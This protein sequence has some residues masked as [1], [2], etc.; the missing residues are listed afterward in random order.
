M[1]I[2]IF[3]SSDNNYAPYMAATIVSI[4]E[5]TEAFIN[6]YILDGGIS[7]QNIEKISSMGKNYDNCSLEFIKLDVEKEFS[8]IK[9][10]NEHC[11]H[12][13][14]SAL[15]RLLI[16]NLKHDLKKVIYLDTDIIAKKDIKS[17]YEY[18]LGEYALGAVPGI[19]K[20][21]ADNG[22]RRLHLSKLHHYFNSGV[23]LMDL[24]KFRKQN[25]VKRFFEIEQKKRELIKYPDQDIL[26]ICFENNYLKLDSIYNY[27]AP[28][29]YIIE[30]FVLRHYITDIKPWHINPDITGF[31]DDKDLFWYYMRKTP[32]YEEVF[33]IFKYKPKNF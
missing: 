17:L 33:Q 16:P 18:D 13:T 28:R 14:L 4:L 23:L 3:L 7:D 20:I 10:N 1:S 32:F 27:T 19:V 21:V 12:I 24:E 30:D 22:T 5:N 8:S 6:F 11:N 2:P 31:V 29:G 9:F 25:I 15:N 26:N